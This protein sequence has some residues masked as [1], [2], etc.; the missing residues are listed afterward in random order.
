ALSRRTGCRPRRPPRAARRQRRAAARLVPA[1]D[2]DPPLSA[3]RTG[4][5]SWPCLA[6]AFYAFNPV[7]NMD[8]WHIRAAAPCAFRLVLPDGRWCCPP[9]G[10]AQNLW[11]RAL[12]SHLSRQCAETSAR[13]RLLP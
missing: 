10:L 8:F 3:T 6:C 12:L 13:A 9:L 11:A 4:D 1:K 7:Q 5:Q 2:P